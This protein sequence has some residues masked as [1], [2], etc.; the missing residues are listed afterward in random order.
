MKL[1]QLDSSATGTASVSRQLTRD[2][3]A[4]QRA[5]DPSVEVIYRDLTQD[6]P[7][8]LD[9]ELTKVVKFR[10][11]ND[12]DDRQR[13]ELALVDTI[14]DELFAAD[15]IVIGAPMYNFSIPT[16]LKAWIDRI[17]QAGRTFKY[18]AEGPQGLVTGK[19]VIIASARGGAYAGHAMEAILDHQEAYLKA[20]LG[21]LGMTDVTVIRVEGQGL[22]PEVK[23]K[24][25][26]EAEVQIGQL[27]LKKA[28]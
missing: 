14:V 2:I 25:I 17:A 6:P 9:A 24:A 18:T 7:A 5:A 16:Q 21:F 12:L 26:A 13:A 15:V 19:R 4:A 20:V 11:L 3:V 8:H 10:D 27:F 23:A 22:G 28:A 1:L